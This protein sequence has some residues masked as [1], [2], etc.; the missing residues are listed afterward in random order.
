MCVPAISL[1]LGLHLAIIGKALKII[2]EF[3]CQVSF[4]LHEMAHMCWTCKISEV[5]NC[6]PIALRNLCPWYSLKDL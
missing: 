6:P 5:S 1:M 4:F 3:S 2:L